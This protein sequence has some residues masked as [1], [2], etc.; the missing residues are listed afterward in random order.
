[1]IFS[2]LG[3]L[4]ADSGSISITNEMFDPTDV[5]IIE[6]NGCRGA[7]TLPADTIL[8]ASSSIS[9]GCYGLDSVGTLQSLGA[10]YYVEQITIK[11]GGHL[12]VA[13]GAQILNQPG[14]YWA[15]LPGGALTVAGTQASPVKLGRESDSWGGIVAQ[16][17]D[18][19]IAHATI[20]YAGSGGAA[21]RA[22]VPIS[23]KNTTIRYSKGWGLSHAASDTTDYATSNTF[24]SNTSG[25]ITTF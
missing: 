11:S 2:S 5:H 25:A 1:M 10:T 23:V 9:V 7:F 17:S 13:P 3:G 12:T 22:E 4:T 24:V 20:E 21:V 8:P 14:A 19:S 16:D 18:V 6:V 15:V